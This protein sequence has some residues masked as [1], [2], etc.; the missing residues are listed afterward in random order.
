VPSLIAVEV[1]RGFETIC[2]G[3][4]HRAGIGLI[5]KI[6]EPVYERESAG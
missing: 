4:T 1:L 6:A 3:H 2:A 5:A